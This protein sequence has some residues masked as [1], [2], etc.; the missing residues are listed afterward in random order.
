MGALFFI[1]IREKGINWIEQIFQ[2]EVVWAL[3]PEFIWF[4]NLLDYHF[5]LFDI[6]ELPEDQR[7][8]ENIENLDPHYDQEN[9]YITSL[10]YPPSANTL[11]Y[12]QTYAWRVTAPINVPLGS[13]TE[14][15]KSV[16]YLFKEMFLLVFKNGLVWVHVCVPMFE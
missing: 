8:A 10:S 9:L 13:G 14:D 5:S 15:Y 4:S 7:S 1:S 6:T 11:E 2:G 3:N 12:N 16:F